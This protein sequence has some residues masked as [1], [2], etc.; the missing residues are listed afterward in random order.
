MVITETPMN[1]IFENATFFLFRLLIVA[2]EPP[3]DSVDSLVCLLCGFF[4][5]GHPFGQGI[6]GFVRVL[7]FQ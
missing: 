7:L 1:M 4:D 6:D 3:F 5:F 2:T